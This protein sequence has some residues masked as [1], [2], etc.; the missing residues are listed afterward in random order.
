MPV[1]LFREYCFESARRL[2]ALHEGHK[3][4][5]VHGH[6]FRMIIHVSGS[7]DPDTGWLMDFSEVD[8]HIRKICEKLDHRLLNDISGLENPTTENIARW[9]WNSLQSELPG[10][11]KVVIQENP[12]SGC[13]YT[14]D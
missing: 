9:V 10:L 6:T 4:G 5:R 7:I 12:F 14:G 3:C 13:S 8:N 2:T 1:E 11:T